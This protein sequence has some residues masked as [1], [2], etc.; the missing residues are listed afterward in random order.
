MYEAWARVRG[1]RVADLGRAAS[2]DG[3]PAH[4]LAISGFA[5]YALLAPEDG[6][7]V[8]EWDAP[9][10]RVRRA[11]V[12]VRTA[13]QPPRPARDGIAGLRRQA[14]PV[15]EVHAG[16]TAVVRR[17]REQPAPLVRDAV[18]GW[19]TGRIERVLGGDFDV[20]TAATP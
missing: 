9:G 2:R 19:R 20:I 10:G 7:H 16:G 3:E 6:L 13:P 12:R 17:Y 1:M 11:T 8:L 15:F 14:D 4:R 5:A 18:R